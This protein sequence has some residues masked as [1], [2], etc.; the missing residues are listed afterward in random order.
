M[1]AR[2]KEILDYL[3]AA[4]A[5]LIDG[6]GRKIQGYAPGNISPTATIWVFWHQGLAAMPEVV[7]L[8]YNSVLRHAG[9][10]PV[11]LVTGA[12]FRDF[13]D[14]PDYVLEKLRSGIITRTHFSDILRAAL[15]SKHGGIWMDATIFVADAITLDAIPFF[16]IKSPFDNFC[17]SHGKWAGLT[18]SNGGSLQ[19]AAPSV[20]RWTGFLLAVDSGENVLFDFMKTIFYAYWKDHE[21]LIDYLFIDYILNIAYDTYPPIKKL[22]DDAPLSKYDIQYLLHD[23]CSRPYSEELFQDCRAKSAFHKL[24]YKTHYDKYTYTNAL[25]V[26]GHI[27]KNYL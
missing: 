23:N 15:L 18:Y 19:S 7:R 6:Y 25:T 26:Y 24:T 27:A 3:T 14:I 8:C 16:T 13:A 9:T 20:N 2:H 1:K 5:P 17:I 11:Q 10:H 22:V 12:N 21:D 4:Y